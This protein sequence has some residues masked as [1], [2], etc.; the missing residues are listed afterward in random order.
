MR[1]AISITLLTLACGLSAQQPCSTNILANGNLQSLFPIWKVTGGVSAF[2]QDNTNGIQTTRAIQLSQGTLF[3]ITAPHNLNLAA[4]TYEFSMDLAYRWNS[5]SFDVGLTPPNGTRTSVG[6]GSFFSNTSTRS[7]TRIAFQ[8]SLPA[9]GTYAFDI[10]LGVKTPNNSTAEVDNIELHPAPSGVFFNVN[11]ANR[12]VGNNSYKIAANPNEFVTVF[13]AG[14]FAGTPTQIPVC[15]ATP[16]FLPL[17]GFIEVVGIASTNGAG[18][19]TG[20]FI[21]PASVRGIPLFWQPIAFSQT[22]CGLGCA[23]M[24]GFP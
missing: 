7:R 12:G 23:D 9:T 13:V 10:R 24:I 22:T 5:S 4:G 20:S 1:F 16:L 15:G 6:N 8:F 2:V 17:T 14:A 3:T 18:I 11:S 19:R 21:V